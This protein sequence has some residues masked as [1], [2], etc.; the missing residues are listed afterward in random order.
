M[1][2]LDTWR[3]TVKRVKIGGLIPI[4]LRAV[5]DVEF[6][7]IPLTVAIEVRAMVPGVGQA[8]GQI[9]VLGRQ[10]VPDDSVYWSEQQ[11]LQYLLYL[12]GSMY[13]HEVAEQFTVDG[14]RP[15]DPHREGG[16]GDKINRGWFR[17]WLG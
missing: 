7:D 13:L 14:E 11:R 1:S 17:M 2:A 12:A 9:L 8:F 10:R 5:P 16:Q 3:D 4:E 6:Y 15:F